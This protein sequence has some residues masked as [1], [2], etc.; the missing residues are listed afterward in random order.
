MK[1]SEKEVLINNK[2]RGG[3]EMSQAWE[4]VRELEN[5]ERAFK[6]LYKENKSYLNQLEKLEIENKKLK[7]KLFKLTLFG[8]KKLINKTKKKEE[9]K[10][11]KLHLRRISNHME[12]GIEY[13]KE[14]LKRKLCMC[15][16][17]LNKCLD[18]LVETKQMDLEFKKGSH[19][20]EILITRL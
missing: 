3:K 18:F 6:N 19:A 4:E 17:D 14:E 16:V 10:I 13:N 11:N 8:E 20:R 9:K 7:D 12:K 1:K 2:T 5:Y 15:N